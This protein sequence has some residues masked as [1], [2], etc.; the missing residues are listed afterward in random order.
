MEVM[1]RPNKET[2]TFYNQIRPWIISGEMKEGIMNYKFSD[3]TPKKIVDLFSE[4]KDKLN[5]PCVIS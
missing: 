4:I 5:Y 3:D 1:A 2:L